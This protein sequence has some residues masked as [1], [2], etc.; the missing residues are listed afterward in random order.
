MGFS[1]PYVQKIMEEYF[2]ARATEENSPNLWAIK[3]KRK[4][5]TTGTDKSDV[6]DKYVVR[7]RHF[8]FPDLGSLWRTPQN[9]TKFLISVIML[10]S[11]GQRK[12]IWPEY[13]AEFP[14]INDP[15]LTTLT[16][17]NT[18][19]ETNVYLEL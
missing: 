15:L 7:H 14:K 17:I 4:N 9:R 13:S 12:N 8:A 19:L 18:T 3:P 1:C 2:T 11:E 6:K 5:M 16:G 10:R